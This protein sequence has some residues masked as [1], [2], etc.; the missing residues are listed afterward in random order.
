VPSN[1]VWSVSDI[2]RLKAMVAA[3][4]SAVRTAV[5]LKR[6][7]ATTKRK[8]WELGTPFGAVV[9]LLKERTG[10]PVGPTAR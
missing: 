3:G 4:A 5:A 10:S 1:K 7:L 2:E 8:A 9:E 6:S